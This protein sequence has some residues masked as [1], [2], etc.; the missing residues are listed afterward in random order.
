MAEPSPALPRHI[1]IIMDGNGRWAKQRGLR[2]GAGHR[3]GIQAIRRV[4]GAADEA[5]VHCLTLYAFSTENWSRPRQEVAT[6]MR[7]FEQTLQAE[8]DELHR[9]GVRIRVI[10]RREQLSTRLQK[11]VEE[12]ER[13]TAQNQ[14]GMLNVA[15]N[16][17][18]RAEIVDGVRQLA[19][20]GA[21]L[22]QLEEAELAGALYTAGLPDPDLIIRTAG[23]MRTSNFLI[24]QAAYAELHVTQTLWP[25]FGAADLQAALIDYAA[26]VRRFGGV[27][28]QR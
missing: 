11:L 6:L 15:I 23:E 13:R 14:T 19:L 4:M 10:G 18:G 12:A 28:D 21:D 16:Y 27:L 9:N 5:G 24:W 20:S 2:R 7:L 22:S 17:G 8:V 3:A 1:G 25:D 26:R